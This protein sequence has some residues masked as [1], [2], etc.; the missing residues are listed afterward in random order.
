MATP[1]AVATT[2]GPQLILWF[3]GLTLETGATVLTWI[4]VVA[5]L[6]QPV[7]GSLIVSVISV[8]ALTTSMFCVFAVNELLLQ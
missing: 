2:P 4:A 8:D 7:M 5:E 3:T 6:T 1:V